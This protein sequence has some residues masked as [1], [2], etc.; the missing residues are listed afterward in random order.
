MMNSQAANASQRCAPVTATSTIW[1]VGFSSPTR[2]TTSTSI[3]FQ[4][5]FASETILSSAFSVI[6]G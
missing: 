5:R 1:S 2:W 4:R 3:T 6:P